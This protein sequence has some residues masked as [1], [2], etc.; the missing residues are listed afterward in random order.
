MINKPLAGIAVILCFLT[1]WKTEAGTLYRLDRLAPIAGTACENYVRSLNDSATVVGRSGNDRFRPGALIWTQTNGSSLLPGITGGGYSTC[2]QINRRGEI[3]GSCNQGN[4]VRPF[5]RRTDGK[6]ID[7]GTLPGD[8]GGEALGINNSGCAAGYSSGPTGTRAVIWPANGGTRA[9]GNFPPSTVSRAVAIN[10]EE[11]VAGFVGD[12]S[13]RRAFLWNPNKG[14]SLLDC[15]QGDTTSEATAISNHR[16]IVGISSGPNGTHAVL[17]SSSKG[18]KNL[19]SL[20][21]ATFC[22]PAAINTRGEVV[23]I[24]NGPLGGRA[25]LLTKVGW[26]DLNNSLLPDAHAVLTSAVGINDRG[27]I[28]ALGYDVLCHCGTTGSDCHCGGTTGVP[29]A[30]PEIVPSAHAGHDNPVQA[31]LLT[32]ESE[33]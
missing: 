33:P 24:S 30:C 19:G 21:G 16:G 15:L 26:I 12:G 20:P 25:V 13:G 27:Q 2:A 28:I 31:Y 8:T 17:W 14:A 11:E 5:L 10:D 1:L 3:A 6:T 4:T 32:R 29:C 23:G 22:R 7:P 18:V 9:V